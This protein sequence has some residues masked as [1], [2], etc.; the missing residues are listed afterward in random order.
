VLRSFSQKKEE[1]IR[2]LSNF[3]N[4][5]LKKWKLKLNKESKEIVY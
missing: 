2:R 1:I 3:G 5:N 4:K